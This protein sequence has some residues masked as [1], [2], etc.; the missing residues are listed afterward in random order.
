MC[1]AQILLGGTHINRRFFLATMNV[2]MLSI[3]PT[4]PTRMSICDSVP[5]KATKIPIHNW[6]VMFSL[7]FRLHVYNQLRAS[8]R[9]L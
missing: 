6:P 2:D 3:M 9:I 7:L 8:S 1:L 4:N 5:E